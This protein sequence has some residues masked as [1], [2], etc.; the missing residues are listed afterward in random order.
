MSAH[1]LTEL[2]IEIELRETSSAVIVAG[3]GIRLELHPDD[4]MTLA[5]TLVMAARQAMPL[6]E[7]GVGLRGLH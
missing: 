2:Y 3:D 4:A 1:H 6:E 7:V 5:E